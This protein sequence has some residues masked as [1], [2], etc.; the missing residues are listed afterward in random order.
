M[1]DI[2]DFEPDPVDSTRQALRDACTVFWSMRSAFQNADR[3]L[4]QNPWELTPQEAFN[5]CG[6][7]AASL[8][9]FLTRLAVAINK[10]GP[11]ATDV[12]SSKP[13]AVTL[14]KNVD[15][16]VTLS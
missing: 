12:A 11:A 1:A 13:E 6:T 3:I 9:D 2:I 10:T 8:V 14:T 7:K 5:A 15:G 4:W 16:T